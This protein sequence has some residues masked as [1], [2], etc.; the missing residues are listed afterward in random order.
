M[1]LVLES[2]DVKL[3]LLTE[4]K[5]ELVRQWRNDPKISQYMEF[6]EYI[7]PEMQR[8][9]F[10]RINNNQ[11]YYFIIVYRNCEAG[12]INIKDIDQDKLEGESGSFIYEDKYLS[13]DLAYR[14]HL[15]MYDYFFNVLNYNGL[16]A[17]IINTN[18]RSIRFTLFLGFERISD[19]E[20]YLSK[21]NYLNNKNRIRYYH[22]FNK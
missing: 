20:Y 6:R 7:T 11:N 22:K 9:W 12:L 17:H 2:Y 15:C 3:V 14:A 19:T 13:T 4:D 18:I 16:R 10:E 21:E 5:I 1:G 8:K